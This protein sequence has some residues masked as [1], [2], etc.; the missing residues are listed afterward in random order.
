MTSQDRLVI[1]HLSIIDGIG[2]AT[3]AHL[4]THK[5]PD[6]PWLELYRFSPTE[7]AALMKLPTDKATRIVQ[8]LE[9]V[10]LLERELTLASQHDIHWCTI[11]DDHYPPLLKQSYAPPSVL[12]WRGFPQALVYEKNLAIVGSR[13]ANRYGEHAIQKLLPELIVQG[14][15]IVS[16]G[17][18]GA[19][20]IVHTETLRA[21]G[22]TVAVLGS[23]L[24]K[25]Y[26]ARNNNLFEHIIQQGGTL[27][28]CFP[29][30]MSAMPGNFPARNR[31]IAGMSKGCLVIQAAVE[32]G[33]LITAHYA[34]EQGKEVFAVPGPI[35]DPLSAGCHALLQQG[36]YLATCSTDIMQV[37]G[38]AT[39]PSRLQQN[40]PS[41]TEADI[42]PLPV[43]PR[44]QSTAPQEPHHTIASFC[45]TPRS[46]DELGKLLGLDQQ[47]LYDVLYNLQLQ[48][49]I[50]QNFAGMWENKT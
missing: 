6:M 25:P 11:F 38:L 35:D 19:D 43:V 22:R 49:S 32:S 5:P 47:A 8:G 1:L 17:A 45:R 40:I 31:I 2:P 37:F 14:W 29:L 39:L 27:V 23:G 15:T 24:L 16:G 18:I 9:Q 7:L 4:A 41:T 30:T 28:S 3:I 42:F 50:R 20:S 36:A 48:G 44:H 33:A 26:P 34:L 21:S 13:A 10:S 46:T 12:Y